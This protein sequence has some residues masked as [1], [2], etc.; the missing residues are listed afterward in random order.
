MRTLIQVGCNFTLDVVDLV[1]EHELSILFEPLPECAEKLRSL[2]ALFG[3][4]C[5]IIVVQAA[6]LKHETSME[7]RRYNKN[8]LSSSL[9]IASSDNKTLYPQ[10]NWT[11]QEIL[12]VKCVS[13]ADY[14]PYRVTTLKID[15]QGCDLEILKSVEPWIR[16]GRIETIQCECDGTHLNRDVRL[17]EYLPDN[18]ESSLLAYMHN[19]P[20]DAQRDPNRVEW[21]PDY[22]FRLRKSC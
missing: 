6:V 15:A 11:P 13:L 8:G 3:D 4:L 16:E 20:Y 19:M 22:T 10:V 9:G 14:M 17:Y 5:S 21:N 18:S 2:Q 1:R 12:R 7:M